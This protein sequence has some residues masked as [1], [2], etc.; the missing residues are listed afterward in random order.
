MLTR[1]LPFVPDPRIDDI[2]VADCATEVYGF[3]D[4]QLGTGETDPDGEPG[5]V[6]CGAACAVPVRETSWGRLKSALER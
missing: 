2:L 5:Y 1:T 3:C 6:A 4:E